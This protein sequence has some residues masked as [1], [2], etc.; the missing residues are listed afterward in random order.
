MR[1]F[2]GRQREQLRELARLLREQNKR[3]KS[4]Q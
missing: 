1:G 4:I 3:L 2:K